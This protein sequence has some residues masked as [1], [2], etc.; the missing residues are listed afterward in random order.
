MYL[1]LHNYIAIIFELNHVDLVI[2]SEAILELEL[3]VNWKQEYCMYMRS[4]SHNLTEQ[5]VCL[6][7]MGKI[8][9]IVP[10]VEA[11]LESLNILSA[12]VNISVMNTTS[13]CWKDS[14]KFWP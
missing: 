4:C 3:I 11:V 6:S 14:L 10:S 8:G 13:S 1:H 12:L 5:N 9:D 7:E 2:L